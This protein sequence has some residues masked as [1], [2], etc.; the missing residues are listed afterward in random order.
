M[1]AL[2][3]FITH[4]GW[5]AVVTV[6]FAESGLMVGFFLPGDSLLFISGTLV[7]QGVFSINIFVFVLLLWCAAV[8]GNSTGYFLGT[9]YGRR[10]FRKEDSRFFRQEYLQEAERFYEAYGPKTIVLAMFVPIVRAFAPVVA[11]IAHMP[12]RKFLL[13]N[14]TGAFIWVVL[15]TLLGYAAGDAI[16]RLGINIEFAALAIIAISLLPGL[17]HVLKEPERRKAVKRHASRLVRRKPR[18]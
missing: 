3:Q 16:E 2:L 12:Y 17:F 7:Q 1:E 8:L 5:L 6:I 15:F 14:L 13:F 10:L 18:P 9:K 11:G 4:F